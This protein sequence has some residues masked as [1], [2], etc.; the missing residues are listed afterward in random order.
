MRDKRVRRAVTLLWGLALLGGLNGCHQP[1]QVHLAQEWGQAIRTIGMVPVV[2]PR[3]DV[4]VGDIFAYPVDPHLAAGDSW[5]KVRRVSAIPRWASVPVLAELDVEYRARPSWPKTPDAF[6]QISPE[7][8]SR[9]WSEPTS[10][11][12]RSLFAPDTVPERLRLVDLQAVTSATLS[13]GDLNAFIP[14]EAV[15]VTM[16]T[17]WLD[18]KAVSI[19]VSAAE[20]YALSLQTLLAQVLAP[21]TGGEQSRYYLKEPYRE[22]LAL[23]SDEGSVWLQVISEVL[24]LRSVDISVQSKDRSREDDELHTSELGTPDEAEAMDTPETPTTAEPSDDTLDPVYA[25]FVRADAINQRLIASDTDDLPGGFVRFL[26]VTDESVSM[27]RIWH[28]G[29]AIGMRGLTLQVDTQT[30]EILQVELM[31][32]PMPRIAPE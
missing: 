16:G 24:Y 25:A 29:I 22:H 17:A 31:G 15:N 1:Q 32:V 5:E 10:P 26:S 3:E 21:V 12:G 11:E 14:T 7:P 28:R 18:A 30:G 27:R 13:E 6:L 9:T 20:S 4:R 19:R 23:I 2:P 8:K